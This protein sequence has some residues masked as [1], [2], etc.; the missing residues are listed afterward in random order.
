V[1]LEYN[2]V[3]GI[4]RAITVPYVEA[5]ERQSAHYTCLY[6]GASL[7]AL[8]DL[9]KQK[10]YRFIGSNSAGN[11]AYFVRQDKLTADVKE[12]VLEQGYV[13]SRF[14]ESRNNDGSL[15]YL[16]GEK[17]L[18]ALK[19]LPVTNVNNGLIEPL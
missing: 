15:S 13:H 6:A 16:A 3:F 8:A 11:N 9:S 12:A 1:I 19:G 4:D 2:S 5:F 7:R 10:G 18:D 17:R 14:R